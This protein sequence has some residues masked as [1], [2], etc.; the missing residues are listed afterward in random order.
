MGKFI[1]HI[2]MILVITMIVTC[3]P[4]TAFA[5]TENKGDKKSKETKASNPPIESMIKHDAKIIK[6]IE[7]K[8]EVNVKHFLKDDMTY[9]AVVY[10]EPVHYLEDGKWKNIDNSLGEK[11]LANNETVIE[12]KDNNFKVKF[13]KNINI[14]SNSKNLVEISKKDFKISWG[15]DKGQNSTCS[16]EQKNIEETNKQLEGKILN[17]INKDKSLS[18]KTKEEKSKIKNVL[19]ENEKKK[20]TPNDSSSVK[21]SNIMP[22]VDLK[23]TLHGND[24]KEDIIIKDKIENYEFK[25]LLKTKKLTPKLKEDNSIIFYSDKECTKSEFQMQAPFMYDAKNN[26]STEIKMTLEN[27]SKGFILTIKPNE[28]WLNSKERSYPITIDPPIQESTNTIE[29]STVPKSLSLN[30]TIPLD[31]RKTAYLKFAL[32]KLTSS[33]VVVGATFNASSDF[34]TYKNSYVY[35]RKVISSWNSS[36][37][38]STNL[39]KIETRVQDYQKII[40]YNETSSPIGNSLQSNNIGN[41]L[42][43][44]NTYSSPSYISDSYVEDYFWDMTCIVKSWYSTG[45]NYGVNLSVKNMDGNTTGSLPSNSMVRLIEPY[46]TVNYIDNSGLRDYLSYHTQDIGRAGTAYT[47]DSSGNLILL[48][49][50]L[51]TNGNRMPIDVKHIYSTSEVDTLQM[52]YGQGWRLNLNE[53]LKLI[54]TSSQSRYEYTDNTGTK[55]NLEYSYLSK[56][57]EDG[58][59]KFKVTKNDDGTLKIVDENNITFNFNADGNLISKMDVNGN[60][61]TLK[62]NGTKVVSVTDGGGKITLLT[63]STDGKLSSI[64][65]SS[66]RKINYTYSGNQLTSITYP[67]G[68]KTTYVYDDGNK[69]ISAI[70]CDGYKIDYDYYNVLPYRV[71][72]IKEGNINGTKGNQLNINYDYNMT[73]YTDNNQRKD[74]YQFDN[75]GKTISVRDDL[76]NAQYYNF[77]YSNNTT[78][79][80]CVSKLQSTTK[81]YL[82]DHNAEVGSYWK[83]GGTEDQLNYNKSSSIYAT[84]DKYMGNKSLKVTK[85]SLG[86]RHYFEQSVNLEKGKTYTLSSYI[87]T[88]N[89]TNQSAGAGISVKYYDGLGKIKTVDSQYISGSND[90]QRIDL[91]FTIP[92][93]ATSNI[94][95]VNAGIINETGI[96]YFDCLQLE[97]GSLPNRYNIVENSD[98]TYGSGIPKFWKSNVPSTSYGLLVN[99]ADNTHPSTFNLNRYQINGKNDAAFEIYQDINIEGK[100]GD[101]FTFGGWAKGESLLLKSNRK[102]AIEISIKKLD[103]TVQRQITQFNEATSDWQYIADTVCAEGDYSG[104]TISGIYNYN[105]NTAYFDGFQLY[106]EKFGDDY[107]YDS[108]GNLDEISGTEGSKTTIGY[109]EN[110][111][112]K[113]IEDGK[114]TSTFEYDSKNNLIKNTSNEGVVNSYTYDTYGNQLTSKIGED[115]SFI[116]TSTE[117]TA[118]GNYTKSE[119]DSLGNTSFTNY[120]E[121]KGLLDNVVDAKNQKISYSYD[122][123]NDYLNSVSSVVGG[124]QIT[125]NYTYENDK[126]KTINHNGF[127]YSFDYD[128]F[129]NNTGVSV[130]S[131]KIITNNYESSTGRLLDSTYGNGQKVG[132]SYDTGDRITG[133]NYNG[134]LRYRNEYNAEG[135]LGYHEDIVNGVNYKYEYDLSNTLKRILDSRGRSISYSTEG[136]NNKISEKVD[137]KI[138]DT[139]YVVDKDSRPKSVIYKRNTSNTVN[140]AY[141]ILGRL[142]SKEIN[143]GSSLYKT[144]YGYVNGSNGSTTNIIGSITN[145]NSSISY[146]YDKNG[147]IETITD[148][149]K[150]IKYYY[151]ELNELIRED[152]QVL[153]KTISYSYDLGGNITDKKEYAYTT[154]SITGL[155]PI[156]TIVYNYGDNNWKDKLTSYNGKAITYDAIGNP[157]TYDGYTY[158]WEM[159]RSLKSISKTGLDISFKYNEQG[160]RTEKTVNGKTTK[161]YLSDDRVTYETDGTDKIYY[162][163]DSDNNLISMNLNGIEYY[164]IRNAQGDII[165]LVDTSGT[166][167]VGYTYDSWGK[168]ISIT[169]TLKDTVGVKNPYLYRGYRYDKETGLYYLQSRYYNAEWGRFINGDALIGETGEIFSHNMFAYCINNPI[170]YSDPSGFLRVRYNDLAK[171]IDLLIYV[172]PAIAAINKTLKAIRKAKYAFTMIGKGVWINALTQIT[173]RVLTK[174]GLKRKL[175]TQI[176]SLINTCTLIMSD[177][178]IGKI[179]AWGI[180]KIFKVKT[181]REKKYYYWGPVISVKYIVFW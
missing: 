21:Y 180:G 1:R 80:T 4:V 133:V 57:Y 7:E 46:F 141:D 151:D 25:F 157:L 6:E 160:I 125:N 66:N 42:Y 15:I 35:L 47:N 50:D 117:Y 87:K 164:Y 173:T 109:N 176:L 20:T 27:S 40:N 84:E 13:T 153:N 121:T 113:S 161:Y 73:I 62:Y 167:V 22:N 152:N 122:A 23:Y 115:A 156:S 59:N 32:P 91:K 90:W 101:N 83:D 82:Q 159:G 2:A 63:Y 123:N 9:E 3:L 134:T 71:Q 58:S 74:V 119:T 55:R 97:D 130:G 76:G 124:K 31:D 68:K 43:T 146:T 26:S 88:T 11:K 92:A 143:S 154:G 98:L 127:N 38:S 135:V 163:Y 41:S 99:S 29:I 162:T 37:I 65:D 140:Y 24:L 144:S 67:D 174:V 60:S 28:E 155:T 77:G 178:S 132:Y 170:N 105:E 129:G 10:P 139:T 177:L 17:R 138:Y 114:G 112:I 128:S 86:N 78:K 79:L 165:G 54:N 150:S 85:G 94:V 175:V 149:G 116:Q 100:Q 110:N 108:E 136:G 5:S 111:D 118:N 131:Q 126:I 52:G 104:I 12:N 106:K 93:D 8:R 14:N 81:N 61:I 75:A 181:Y 64:T 107:S 53:T 137:N 34:C 145:G 166:Q 102:F 179:V 56:T 72:N 95:Q 142:S 19:V 70:N 147:N 171:M 103:G 89:V 96:A 69:L 44:E 168:L 33:Q 45:E 16:V 148:G 158:T 30:S 49:N 172:I 48:H 120:N 39:P 18:K 169:G 51:S 36:T